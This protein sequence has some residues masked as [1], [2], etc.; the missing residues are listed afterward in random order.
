M[1]RMRGHCKLVTHTGH[2][3]LWHPIESQKKMDALCPRGIC[4]VGPLILI[5][6]RCILELVHF[7]VEHEAFV[8]CVEC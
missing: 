1:L 7:H 3:V 2:S 8:F 4:H 5:E 6:S